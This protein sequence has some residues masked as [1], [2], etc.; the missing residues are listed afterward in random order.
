MGL[1]EDS[2]DTIL[3]HVMDSSFNI[4]LHIF[5]AVLVL[6]NSMCVNYVMLTQ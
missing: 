6:K 2:V 3:K 1:R 4:C 5:K